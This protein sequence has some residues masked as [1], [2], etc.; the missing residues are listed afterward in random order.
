MYSAGGASYEP[1]SRTVTPDKSDIGEP[2]PGSNLQQPKMTDFPLDH[3][4]PVFNIGKPDSNINIKH[5][6]GAKK[7]S[8]A[9]IIKGNLQKN[10]YINPPKTT[11]EPDK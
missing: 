10:I 7:V 6:P 4:L 2:R 8:K 9:V 1:H 11:V 5:F 3:I